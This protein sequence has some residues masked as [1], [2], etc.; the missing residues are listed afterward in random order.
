MEKALQCRRRLQECRRKC[1]VAERLGKAIGKQRPCKSKQNPKRFY[2]WPLPL[3]RNCARKACIRQAQ[4]VHPAR[5]QARP[6]SRR[7][8]SSAQGRGPRLR[9]QS[10]RGI[11]GGHDARGRQGRQDVLRA[12]IRLCARPD[13]PDWAPGR[14]SRRPQMRDGAGRRERAGKASLPEEKA[15]RAEGAHP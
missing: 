14:A 11:R 15:V 3:S 4:G 6:C 1:G 12:G 7:R 8:D 2:V 13:S 10:A 5:G 9:P